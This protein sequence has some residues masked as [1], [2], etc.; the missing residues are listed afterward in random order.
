MTKPLARLLF[1]SYLG[2][3]I[4]VVGSAMLMPGAVFAH[5]H[6]GIS[7][8]GSHFPSVI[9]YVAGLTVS[10]ICLTR[11][12]RQIADYPERL[13][14]MR[15][16]LFALAGGIVL[17]LLTPAQASR[18]FYWGHTLA[19]I[20]L[21]TVTG[22]GAAWVMFYSDRTML[23]WLL[24]VLFATGTLAS[25]FAAYYV[26]VP[27]LLAVGQ[28]VAINSSSFLFIRACLRWNT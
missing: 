25:L 9:P 7:F 10:V 18:S 6:R 12:A 5:P 28:I 17:L 11:A 4:A 14:A 26:T 19:A 8:W 27:G 16:L 15:R 24:C 2:F 20:S 21:F 1:G 22:L 23:D 3:V 13:H